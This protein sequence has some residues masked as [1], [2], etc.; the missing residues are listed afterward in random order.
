LAEVARRELN[1]R[2]QLAFL[3]SDEPAWKDE[4]HPELK[5]GTAAWVRSLRQESDSRLRKLE[6]HK[7][8][9]D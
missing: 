3:S 9:I 6:E 7:E 4:D 5:D 8:R 2:K 1:K